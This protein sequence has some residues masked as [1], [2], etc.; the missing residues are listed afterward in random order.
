[1]NLYTTIDNA[2]V[3]YSVDGTGPSNL[4]LV[5][6]AGAN[7]ETNWGHFIE[8]FSPNYKVVRPNLSGSGE[9]TDDGQALTTEILAKQVIAAA[10]AA[11]AIPFDLIGFSMGTSVATY[12]AAEYPEYVKSVVLLAPFLKSNARTKLQLE[13]WKDLSS[14]NRKAM[15]NL[16]IQTGFSANFTSA[17][18]DETITQTLENTLQT[19]NWEGFIRQAELLIHTDVTEQAKNV[20]SPTLVI[21][22]TYDYMAPSI[23]AK[24]AVKFIPDAQYAEL[25]T[26]HLAIYEKPTE[27]LNLVTEFFKEK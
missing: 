19:N 18:D 12:I 9:T 3:S 14:T 25:E 4:V 27:F 23:F 2:N 24:D 17:W 21:G 20:S 11:N 6:G 8:Y 13:L 10:K 1:M 7:S 22:C 26:G 15:S 16:I 5:H